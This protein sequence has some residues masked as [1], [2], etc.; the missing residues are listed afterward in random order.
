G[1]GIVDTEDADAFADPE[2][3]DV[4]KRAPQPLAVGV[5]EIDVDDV[6]IFLRG[7]LRI[8]DGAVRPE[9]E[10][11]GV[12]GD[13]RM[14]GRTWDGEGERHLEPE[15]VRRGDETA[16]TVEAAEIRMDRG[17]AAFARP[18]RIGAAGIAGRGGERIVTSLA[19]DPAD[20]MDRR[21]ID[22]VEAER[23]DL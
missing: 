19:V 1:V 13:P 2:Q 4:A 5:V 23:A 21:Q 12:L 16:K 20:G 9:D 14:V 6:L 22:H 8:F 11:L 10:P 15:A 3:D 17:V 7:I 18:D